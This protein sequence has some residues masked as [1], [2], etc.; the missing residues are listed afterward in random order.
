MSVL[1]LGW[2]VASRVLFVCLF[3]LAAAKIPSGEATFSSF[4]SA[5]FANCNYKVVVINII[6]GDKSGNINN[7][8][9]L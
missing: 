3:A 1:R 6:N 8:S 7:N 2:I 4:R 9:Q 5:S